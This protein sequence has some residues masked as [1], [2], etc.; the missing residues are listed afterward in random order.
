MHISRDIFA[1]INMNGIRILPFGVGWD[2]F[3]IFS[4]YSHEEAVETSLGILRYL[5]VVSDRL[6]IQP[7]VY[8]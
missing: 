2:Y 1:C 4:V 3:S 5:I 8:I 7:M 6:L